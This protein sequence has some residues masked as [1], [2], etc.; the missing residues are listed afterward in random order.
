M[1]R[2]GKSPITIPDKVQVLVNGDSITA[3]GPKGELNFVKSELIS[4]EQ[5]GN[6]LHVKRSSDD[7]SSRSLHGLTRSLVFN[8][9]NGVS[10]GYKKILQI[11]GVGFKAEMKGA[12]LFLSLGFSHPIIVLP[13][14]GVTFT[15]PNATTVEIEGRDKQL[16]G[17]VAFKIKK[18]RKPEP[19]KGKGIRYQGEYIRRKAGKSASKK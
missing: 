18:L 4:L 5:D 14:D 1:S 2:I 6:T 16:V 10:S 8:M 3:K 19:Y 9:V 13:P 11:E 7:K 17:E 15:T 12:R